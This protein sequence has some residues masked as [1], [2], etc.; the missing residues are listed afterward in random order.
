MRS[1]VL[2]MWVDVNVEV[3]GPEPCFET[4]DGSLGLK[5]SL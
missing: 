2:V 5:I 4:T 1:V 3:D